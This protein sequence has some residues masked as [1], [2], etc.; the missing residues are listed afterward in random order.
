MGL[1]DLTRVSDCIGF[2]WSRISVLTFGNELGIVFLLTASIALFVGVQVMF[3]L[4]EHEL[5][6]GIRMKC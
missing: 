2:C 1:L 4:R 3:E 6:H 5:R